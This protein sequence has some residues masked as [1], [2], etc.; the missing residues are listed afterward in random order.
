MNKEAQYLPWP[1]SCQR[2]PAADGSLRW[3][4]WR[5][6][7]GAHLPAGPNMKAWPSSGHKHGAWMVWSEEWLLQ[8]CVSH[9]TGF[10]ELLLQ[11]GHRH[12][13]PTLQPMFRESVRR[14]GGRVTSM[15]R[16]ELLSRCISLEPL[17]LL[18]ACFGAGK[19]RDWWR[20]KHRQLR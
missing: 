6:A 8:R 20:K 13:W 3:R 15:L 17:L 1:C 10:V 16:Y 19:S 14:T 5:H 9:L 2:I 4:Q 18:R 7:S 12:P 11:A